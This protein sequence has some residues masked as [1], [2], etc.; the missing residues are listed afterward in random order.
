M[1]SPRMNQLRLGV[2]IGGISTLALFSSTNI[3]QSKTHQTRFQPLISDP[4][5][6]AP[7]QMQS[8]SFFR[9][10]MPFQK[11]VQNIF[12]QLNHK[13]LA[14]CEEIH[15]ILLPTDTDIIKVKVLNRLKEYA[16]VESETKLKFKKESN[17]V[18]IFSILAGKIPDPDNSTGLNTARVGKT[19]I[20][21]PI[22]EVAGAWWNFNSRREWDSLNTAVSQIVDIYGEN[23]RLV[24]IKGK[25]KPMI[26]AR[27]FGFLSCYLKPEDFG[28]PEESL[29][30][31][32]VDASEIVPKDK[33]SVR[34]KI[35]SILVLEP[36]T[37]NST[38]CTY[39]CEVEPQG[40]LPHVA[41]E[42]AAD[43]L[44]GTL[45]VLKS[46]LESN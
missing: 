22:Q 43:D 38:A 26:S 27:D 44:P 1:F 37:A 32:Q 30:F 39:V 28:F 6:E 9:I 29:V 25:P 35:N 10:S 45:G 46:H 13:R 34:G 18:K 2:C 36:I 3:H 42:L 8:Q 5:K 31:L 21:A 15:Q 40:W 23:Q 33:S 20:E 7:T 12:T 19:I 4:K 11:Q 16:T 14:L 41:V 17:G 24:Y